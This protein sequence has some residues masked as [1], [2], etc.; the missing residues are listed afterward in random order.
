[1]IKEYKFE[2]IYS[3][4]KHILTKGSPVWNEKTINNYRIWNPRR[5]KLCAMILNKC[6]IMPI[7]KNST[8]LYLGASS[9]TTVSYVSDIADKGM[10][11][12]V[13]FSGRVFRDLIA[14]CEKR[15]NIVPILADANQPESYQ[16]IVESVDVVYQDIAQRNQ[17]QIFKKNAKMFLKKNGYGI[18]MVKARSIDTTARPEDVYKKAVEDLKDFEILEKIGLEPYCKDHLAVALENK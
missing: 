16:H 3:D 11:Y 2:N 10:I 13:E 18:I 4:G 5:S 17:I 7:K 6:K 9:G 15:K 1:M 12:C 14:M 8:V